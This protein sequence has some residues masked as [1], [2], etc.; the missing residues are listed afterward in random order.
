MKWLTMIMSKLAFLQLLRVLNLPFETIAR[1][2][3][4]I[5]NAIKS[6]M[7]DKLEFPYEIVKKK[8]RSKFFN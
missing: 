2:I 7:P 6:H 4:G 5:Y 1:I 3:V 8:D